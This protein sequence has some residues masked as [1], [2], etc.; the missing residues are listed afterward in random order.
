MRLTVVQ[1]DSRQHQKAN[2]MQFPKS[3]LGHLPGARSLML[4]VG[5]LLLMGAWA[6]SSP[7]G[8]APDEPS[9]FAKTYALGRGDVFG[10]KIKKTEIPA[11]YAA[12][13]TEQWQRDRLVFEA[14]YFR[15]PAK[16]IPSWGYCVLYK[17]TT[18]PNTCAKPTPAPNGKMLSSHG[19]YQPFL[20][21]VPALFT[22]LFPSNPGAF[23]GARFGV[24]LS[25]LAFVWFGLSRSFRRR[26]H[27]VILATVLAITP[28]LLFWSSSVAT[29]GIEAATSFC[30]TVLLLDEDRTRANHIML[31]ASGVAL[32][33]TRSTGPILVAIIV[34]LALLLR[35]RTALSRGRRKVNLAGWLTVGSA[36]V[37]S[38]VWERKEKYPAHFPAHVTL[39]DFTGQMSELPWLFRQATSVFG[40]VDV[41]V[42]LYLHWIW[43]TLL[44]MVLGFAFFMGT[45]RQ[46]LTLA[47]ALFMVP[48]L[49]T[50]MGVYLMKPTGFGMQ[51]RFVLPLGVIVPAVAASIISSGRDELKNV[52]PRT[53]PRFAILLVGLVQL[54]ALFANSRRYAVGTAG[55]MFF[56]EH[57]MWGPRLGWTVVLGL[58]VL[59]SALVVYALAGRWKDHMEQGEHVEQVEQVA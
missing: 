23:Y 57:P 18:T 35:G 41:V 3:N 20:Y 51:G 50:A 56:L 53:M 10:E 19:A 13:G 29:G 54:A 52:E 48:V 21:L 2:R 43:A 16:A 6:M 14:R 27:L 58:G 44:L 31:F 49:T 1:P 46:R 38:A 22:R 47:L 25:A 7:P 17:L 4:L 5:F 45:R 15:V 11:E 26:N 42:S 59:G 39:K 33:L 55:P 36:C 40:A 28:S 12:F 34:V 8:V 9:H 30:F 24:I 32:A 37:V